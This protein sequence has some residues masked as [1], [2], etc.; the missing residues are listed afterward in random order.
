MV[1][2]VVVAAMVVSGVRVWDGVWVGVGVG[3]LLASSAS[4]ILMRAAASLATDL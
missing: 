1:V 3:A 2:V 4:S